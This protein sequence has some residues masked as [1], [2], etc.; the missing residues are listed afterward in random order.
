MKSIVYNII[1]AALVLAAFVG[2]FSE[3]AETL[4]TMQW[5]LSLIATKAI[6]FGAVYAIYRL[7]KQNHQ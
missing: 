6:G 4:P 2:L 5:A 7:V 3:P 1:L